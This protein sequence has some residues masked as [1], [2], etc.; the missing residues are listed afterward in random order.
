METPESLAARAEEMLNRLAQD[1]E[2]AVSQQ[3]RTEIETARARASRIAA[4]LREARDIASALVAQ[5]VAVDTPVPS[6]VLEG[7]SRARTALRS[8]AT[9]AVGAPSG[10]VAARVQSQSVD[11]ALANADK[12][13]KLLVA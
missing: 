7:A 13:A 2:Q 12:L 5:D 4:E 10:E 9:F 1:K 6:T 8:A 3:T 11:T